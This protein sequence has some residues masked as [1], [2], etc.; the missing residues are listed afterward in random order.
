MNP[1][2]RNLQALLDDVLPPAGEDCG[3]SRADVSAMLRSERHRRLR[4]RTGAAVLAS[5]ALVSG[6]L[7]CRNE[8][9]ARPSVV[10]V[11]IKPSS[12]IVQE[13]NDDQLLALLHGMPAALMEWPNG[14]RTLLVVE[15]AIPP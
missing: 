14:E 15:H 10:E 1:N 9:S 11:P 6:F 13:V 7:L 3:P 2:K 12:I 5:I 4:L 8:H